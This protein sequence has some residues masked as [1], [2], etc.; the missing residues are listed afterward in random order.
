MAFYTIICMCFTEIKQKK[1]IYNILTSHNDQHVI[2][3]Y[4][5]TT[6]FKHVVCDNIQNHQRLNA[7]IIEQVRPTY[8][9]RYNIE[10]SEE[11]IHIDL[12]AKRVK[13]LG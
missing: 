7:L 12:R 1:W 13:P 10:F 5:V 3:P 11:N 2:S 9:I 6:G 8:A 4:I